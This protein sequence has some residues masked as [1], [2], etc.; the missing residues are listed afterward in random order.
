[1]RAQSLSREDPLEEEMVT[2]SSILAW[3]MSGTG[4]CPEARHPN[5][6][7][8]PWRLPVRCFPGLC[9]QHLPRLPLISVL[10]WEKP[11]P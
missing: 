5:S 3:G 6:R 8:G 10:S 9:P 7:R 11:Q 1:M 2:H 4:L